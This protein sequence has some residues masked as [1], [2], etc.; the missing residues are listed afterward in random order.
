MPSTPE[1]QRRKEMMQKYRDNVLSE[2]T[3]KA[4]GFPPGPIR[5]DF[6]P[7]W[8]AEDIA[9]ITKDKPKEVIE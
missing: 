5:H 7:L 1:K 3:K 9:A 4:F 6:E 2:K 8:N